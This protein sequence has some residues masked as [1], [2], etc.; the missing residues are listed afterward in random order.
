M[1][2][3]TP[4]L[5][6]RP[7]SPRHER[8][9]AEYLKDGNATQA[10]IRAGYASRGA[11]PSASRLLRDP[12]IEAAIAA[13]R[14]HIAEALQVSVERVTQEYAK[15]AFASVDDFVSTDDDG[16]LRIDLAKANQAQRAGLLELRVSSNHSKQ[17]QRVTLRL[18]KLQALAALTRQLGGLA[19]KPKPQSAATVDNLA[20][21][22]R[23]ARLLHLAEERAQRAERALAEARAALAAAEAG[24]KASGLENPNP[25]IF[26]LSRA[27]ADPGTPPLESAPGAAKAAAAA[28]PQPPD[29]PQPPPRPAAMPGMPTEKLPD[30]VPG[31]HPDAKFKWS[32]G[33]DVEPGPDSADALRM[34]RPGGFPDDDRRCEPVAQAS[35]NVSRAGHDRMGMKA[36]THCHPERSEG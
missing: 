31:L 3:P 24:P 27:P 34:M 9:V 11:Q 29:P 23:N 18:G 5:S 32:G 35:A 20:E 21:D 22:L 12:G 36:T 16:R 25:S 30:H 28:A 2:D 4:C 7:L 13:G 8:F 1:S 6:P 10:Y 15:I 19:A 17:E 14:Q 33:R 26:P